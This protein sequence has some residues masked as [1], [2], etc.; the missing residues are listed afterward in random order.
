MNRSTVYSS[1]MNTENSIRTS[2]LI[3]LTNMNRSTVLAV[4]ETITA[5]F[6]LR[7][8]YIACLIAKLARE[9]EHI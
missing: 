2:R 1:V 8:I 5:S 4:R 9:S 6:F 3:D 7:N